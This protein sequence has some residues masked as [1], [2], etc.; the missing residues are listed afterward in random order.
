MTSY[1]DVEQSRAGRALCLVSHAVRIVPAAR[2]SREGVLLRFRVFPALF[3]ALTPLLAAV[4]LGGLSA[5]PSI[6]FGDPETVQEVDQLL[7]GVSMDFDPSNRAHISYVNYS[8]GNIVMYAYYNG[9]KWITQSLPQLRVLSSISPTSLRIDSAGYP[10]IACNGVSYDYAYKDASGWHFQ[11]VAGRV[12]SPSLRFGSD[13]K[14][15]L[16]YYDADIQAYRFG[17]RSGGVWTLETVAPTIYHSGK[18]PWEWCSLVLDSSDKPRISFWDQD[19]DTLK[20]AYKSG[21]SW[22]RITVD[23]NPAQVGFPNSI[24]LDSSGNPHIIYSDYTNHRVRH[25]WIESALWK[26]E[27]ITSAGAAD[28][29]SVDMSPSGVL[30][31]GAAINGQI[32]YFRKINN[33]SSWVT[34][35]TPGVLQSIGFAFNNSGSPFFAMNSAG[36]LRAQYSLYY[37]AFVAGSWNRTLIDDGGF[38]GE[39]GISISRDGRWIAYGSTGTEQLRVRENSVLGYRYGVM[40]V[41]PGSNRSMSVDTAPDGTVYASYR[42]TI[43]G[44]LRVAKGPQGPNFWNDWEIVDNTATVGNSSLTVGSTGDIYVSYADITSGSALRFARKS[45]GAW[46]KVLVDGVGHK[47]GDSRIALN[48]AGQ[49]RIAYTDVLGHQLLIAYSNNQGASWTTQTIDTTSVQFQWPSLAYDTSNLPH[50][51]YLDS[52]PVD[53][54]YARGPIESWSTQTVDAAGSTGLYP[55]L[56]LDIQN[57]P[58]ISYY[59]NTDRVLRCAWYDGSTWRKLSLDT[60]FYTGMNSSIAVNGN[61]ID[62]AYS[63]SSNR[64]VKKITGYYDYT[65]PATPVVTDAGQFTTNASQLWASWTASDPDS[66]I[67]GYEYAIGTSPTDPGSG[68][69]VGW[70]SRSSASVTHTGLSLVN[71]QTY[72]FYV[73]AKNRAGDWSAVGVSDGIKVVTGALRIADAKQLADGV[74]VQLTGKVVSRNASF[75]Y[76][77][78]QEPDRSSGITIYS[79]GGGLSLGITKG[80][81]VTV[82]GRMGHFLGRRCLYDPS[83]SI[84]GAT[85][86]PQP[87]YVRGS[88]LGGSPFLYSAGPPE[89]GERGYPGSVGLNNIGLYLRISGRVTSIPS[90]ISFRIND[91]SRVDD[92]SVGYSAGPLPVVGDYVEAVGYA[93]IGAFSADSWVKKD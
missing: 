64:S 31:V 82:T 42:N 6:Q 83:V 7:N 44:S 53:L 41:G 1:R 74:W 37:T 43:D 56:A 60:A 61:R 93:G 62:I 40:D 91:G 22:I 88:Q 25:A 15:R 14:L 45:G 92:I 66:G 46:T 58:I 8:A 86:P 48:T 59:D 49:P 12:G 51:A 36:T 20:Y 81:I 90:S 2:S 24:E 26:W 11:D 89:T 85:A 65:A 73:R 28:A 78:V 67:D 35:S 33:S 4:S 10:H 5:A 16:A 84:T 68:Y 79:E 32:Y 27:D 13:G 3:C 18:I 50:V 76:T 87:L 38:F 30:G 71:G 21:A 39:F 9:T 80:K 54:K 47:G 69:T 57:R 34:S 72:Y 75:Y 23:G 29:L 55:S 52:G 70:T 63:D 19:A 17:V 77:Y